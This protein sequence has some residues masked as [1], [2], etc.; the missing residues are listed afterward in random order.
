MDYQ[1]DHPPQDSSGGGQGWRGGG[2]QVGGR[3]GIT[4]E[5]RTHFPPLR[6]AFLH[7]WKRR[8]VQG[9]MSRGWVT[10]NYSPAPKIGLVVTPRRAEASKPRPL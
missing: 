5:K 1:P 6:S 8:G 4:K 7:K 10:G 3:A 9:N 2:Q